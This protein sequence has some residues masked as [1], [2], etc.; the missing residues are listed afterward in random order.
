MR[1]RSLAIGPALI[2]CLSVAFFATAAAAEVVVE[3]CLVSAIDDV[4][5][6]AEESGV[7]I[8]LPAKPGQEVKE[9]DLLGKI[10]D[11]MAVIA[12]E[13]AQN[14]Y[15]RHKKRSEND[16]SVRFAKKSYEVALADLASNEAANAE[17]PGAVPETE[18]R[19]K[20][21]KTEETKLG[22][23]QAT[24]TQGL[25]EFDVR[26]ALGEWHA[27]NDAVK[28]RRILSPIEGEVF[29][30]HRNRGEWVQSGET[31]IRVVHMSRLQ[32]HGFLKEAEHAR[33]T[34]TDHP[35]RVVVNME[36]G[37]TESFTGKIVFASSETTGGGEFRVSAEVD[38]RKENGRWL[39]KPG[40]LATMTIE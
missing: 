30:V 10:D 25:I 17:V 40:Q 11:K 19:T 32:I 39:L 16:I 7:L 33:D 24:V 27:A 20:R 3:N 13:A 28:R 6:P 36:G 15:D 8:E 1:I 31:V 4:D 26:K 35:I 34:V 22:I 18:M 14:E 23:E 38:N 5:V 21:L 12:R 9:D 37:R 29:E 2:A